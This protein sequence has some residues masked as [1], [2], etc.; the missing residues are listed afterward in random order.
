MD[1]KFC[2][3]RSISHCFQDKCI[4]AFYAE[5]QD[6]HRKW[7]EKYFWQTGADDSVHHA[8]QNF[9]KIALFHTISE[10]NAFL[11]ITQKFKMAAKNDRKTIFGKQL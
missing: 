8:G 6:G 3:N 7:R 5:F 9:V 4:F 1:Q 10:I 2:R 11:P